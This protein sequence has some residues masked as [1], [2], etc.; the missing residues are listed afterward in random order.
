V[1]SRAGCSP[2]TYD[3]VELPPLDAAGLRGAVQ[4]IAARYRLTVRQITLALGMATGN[5]FHQGKDFLPPKIAVRLAVEVMFGTARMAP[6]TDR[7]Q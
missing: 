2:R 3:A 4:E 6:L 1:P 7:I 5:L